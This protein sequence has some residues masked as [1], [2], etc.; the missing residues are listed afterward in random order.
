MRIT[1]LYLATA[2]LSAMFLS[3]T[4]CQTAQRPA[5]LLPPPQANA[6]ALTAVAVPAPLATAN[7]QP[8]AAQPVQPQPKPDPV[9][10]LIA[11]V[12][13]EYQA[14]QDQ[15]KA[16]KLEAARHNFEHA[17]DLLGNQEYV[18]SDE[19]IQHEFDKILEAE[20]SPEL[21][22]LQESD[23]GAAQKSEPAPIDEVNEVTPPVDARVKAQ[24]E[25]EVKATYSD[26]PLMLTDPVAGYINYFSTRGRETLEHALVRGGRYHDMIQKTLKDQ[27]VPQE[28]I[29]LAQAESGFHPLAVSRA[30][31]RGMWQFMG[32]RARGYGLERNSWV[33]ERQD[34]E[35]ATRAAARHL[36]DLYN[37]FGD[38]YLAMAAYNSGPGTVQQ[39][40]KRTGYADFWELYRRNVLT[41]ETRNYVPII[42][43]VT[44]MAKNP[45]QYRLDKVVP[46]KP[47]PYD[48]L[49]IGYAV[50]L[51]LVAQCVD[52][53][54]A[55]LQDFNPSLL[56]WTT[57][58]DQ[59]FEL[60]LPAGTKDTYLSAIASIPPDMR[61]W[62]RYHKVATGDTLA[63]VARTYRTNP[64]AIA[65]VNKL[66]G[67]EDLQ[68]E[69]K[70]IIPIIPGKH[71]TTEDAA[72][73]TRRA[74]RYTVR[75]GDTVQS[76]ADN[77]GVAPTM[78]RRWNRL[79]GDS[80]RGRRV[81][82]VHLPVTPSASESRQSVASKSKSKRTLHVVS[83]KSLVRH[84]VK[85]GETLTSIAS[86][87][88]TTVAALKRDNGDLAS[89]RPGM[90]LVIKGVQ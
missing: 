76:V 32:S 68:P 57:P 38:W 86:T 43:A 89:L 54:A 49:K 2:L 81:L 11:H 31:A 71:A 74:T 39:A 47:V 10:E 70:L 52:S 55:A 17:L 1:K 46:E 66:D 51:R 36:K 87:H 13:K 3:T 50:D 18:L 62:W 7:A 63:A 24:A 60:H 14:G 28:L 34:P 77:F 5:A 82:Y 42:V 88:H 80:L 33:D 78:V 58:K 4:A 75:K 64:R 44:I 22:A 15:L 12:E 16:G 48:T 67:D 35:K 19:R 29:Y 61:V 83:D 21:A 53:S 6:P 56:R 20:N 26:L 23:G 72:T 90:I 37:Q 85:P 8:A 69:S 41:K 79:K 25:A 40:V 9:A 27:G 84:K 59:P 30:G 73:Y 45:A 65:R